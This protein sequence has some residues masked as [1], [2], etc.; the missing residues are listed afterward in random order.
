MKTIKT[1]FWMILQ[2]EQE[3]RKKLLFH[4]SYYFHYRLRI[5]VREAF[6]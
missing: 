5:P 4:L 1:L 3:E 2:R 6:S